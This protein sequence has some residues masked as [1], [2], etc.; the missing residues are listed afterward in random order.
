MP[1][2]ALLLCSAGTMAISMPDIV[3]RPPM[4]IGLRCFTPCR[5]IHPASSGD[6]TTMAPVS[7]ATAG[8]SSQ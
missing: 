6:A 2:G 1:S 4:F 7:R 5:S 3:W 8:A